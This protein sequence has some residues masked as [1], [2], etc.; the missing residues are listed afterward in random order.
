MPPSE[1]VK[2]CYNDIQV[3]GSNLTLSNSNSGITKTVSV[4]GGGAAVTGL[5]S[6]SLTGN[7]LSFTKTDG[8]A[9]DTIDLTT[10]TLGGVAT[11]NS[12]DILSNTADIDNLQAENRALVIPEVLIT[13]NSFTAP[14]NGKNYV[15]QQ[16]TYE[17]A[18]KEGFYAFIKN[19]S[20]YWGSAHNYDLFGT[21]SGD[22]VHFNH[23]GTAMA[24]WTSLYAVSSLGS[25]LV[26]EL[27]ETK[28]I[29]SFIIRGEA[30]Q[31]TPSK[32]SLL[33]KTT[34]NVWELLGSYNQDVATHEI[35]TKLNVD[36]NSA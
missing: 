29:S 21:D 30:T 19:S 26:L 28:V 14:E 6:A 16:S 33:G 32:F 13:S 2:Q 35:G 12:N 11:T 5:N 20:L 1:R 18:N 34:S 17:S 36:I 25:V 9:A 7:T 8:T 15:V 3:N 31:S 27:P 24:S 4:T 22:G 10:S 23:S